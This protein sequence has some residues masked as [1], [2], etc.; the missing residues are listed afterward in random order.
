MRPSSRSP[1]LKTLM[2]RSCLLSALLLLSACIL[3]EDFTPQWKNSATDPC[4]SKIAESLYYSEFRRDPSNIDLSTLARYIHTGQQHFLLLK[5]SA[6]Q[7]GGRLYRFDVLKTGNYTIFRRYRLDPTMRSTFEKDY[8]AAPVSFARG[9][10]RLASLGEAELTLL[11]EIS[12]KPEYW[13]TEDQTLYNPSN[14]PLCTLAGP[15]Q[16]D[17]AKSK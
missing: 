2:A 15:V 10:V 3:V 1:L 13:Q 9:S 11:A 6:D 7:A 5:K 12:A 16:A 8:P 4:I 17:A 14:N